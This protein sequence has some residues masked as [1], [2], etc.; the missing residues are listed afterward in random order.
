MDAQ[1]WLDARRRQLRTVQNAN[2]TV[3]T[4]CTEDAEEWWILKA[5]G[6]NGGGDVHVLPPACTHVPACIALRPLDSYVVQR[7]ITRPLLLEKKYK[8]HYRVYALLRMTGVEETGRTSV[9]REARRARFQPWIYQHG[10]ILRASERY[11]HATKCGSANEIDAAAHL[12]NLSLNKHCPG[13]PGQLPIDLARA[14][15]TFG[16]MKAHWA[17]VVR[18]A[19]PF[20][21]AQVRH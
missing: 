11:H 6:A 10:F 7:Y 12:T 16:C 21:R 19:A 14:P 9:D 2:Y 18:A 1:A 20:L 17:A 8:F 3:F 13:Y 4:D 15:R 5:A